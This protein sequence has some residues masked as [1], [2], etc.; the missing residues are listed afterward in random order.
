VAGG[1]KIHK[2][3]AYRFL[4]TLKDRGLVEQDARTERYRLGLGLVYLASAVTA[5]LD[6]VREARPVCQRLSE[7]TQETVTVTVLVGDEAII[8]YQATSPSSVLGVD[9]TGRHT[10]LH[11]TS[12]GKVLL[13]HLPEGRRQ[14]LLARP[15]ERFT[16]NTIVDA[17]RL[18]E[19]LSTMRA[20]GYSHTLEEYEVGLTGIAAPIYAA[21]GDVVAALSVSGPAFRLPLTS[22]PQLGELTAG[23]AADISRR[24]GFQG[25]RQAV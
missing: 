22:I 5:E 8:I 24:L 17:V 3:T 20:L 18:E 15:L 12:D 25:P 11:C 4:A 2:S 23:A 16:P 21:T 7:Q 10:P 1:L 6:L 19:Q 14:R 13:A 9:W